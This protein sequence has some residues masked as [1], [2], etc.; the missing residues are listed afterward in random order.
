MPC[1]SPRR[2]SR[3]VPKAQ[4]EHRRPNKKYRRLSIMSTCQHRTCPHS[5]ENIMYDDLRYG[6]STTV[7][8]LV[9]RSS[10]CSGY[11]TLCILIRNTN[12][13]TG[14]QVLF[15]Q[16]IAGREVSVYYN[17]KDP[18]SRFRSSRKVFLFLK[19]AQ[20]TIHS[21]LATHSSL[22]CDN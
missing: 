2:N 14:Y 4:R 9:E 7:L 6:G 8:P 18:Q 20:N 19:R 16:R 21:M 1:T 5:Y 13:K 11:V 15:I 3:S 17:I 22:A 10:P 12:V